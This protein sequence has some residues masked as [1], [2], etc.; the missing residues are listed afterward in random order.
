MKKQ[1]PLIIIAI[2]LII[3]FLVWPSGV[4]RPV[5]NIFYLTVKPLA[6]AGN[7]TI[8]RVSLF[9]KNFTHLGQLARENQELIKENLDL[10]SQ[11]SLLKEA[12]HENEVLKKELGFYQANNAESADKT[13]KNP[14]NLKLLPANIIG[15]SVTGYL[16][17][18]V[19]DRGK[20]DGVQTGQAIVSQGY[21]IGTVKEVLADTSEVTL[22]TDYNSLVPVILQDSRATGLLRGGLSGL[23]VEDIPL[24][25]TINPGE[26]V[27]TSGLGGDIPFGIMVGKVGEVISKKSEIFQKVTLNSPIQ[28]YYLEF[29]FVVQP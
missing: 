17:T 11:L 19:I 15:R 10:Q 9:F 23:T 24:N 6:I 20:K 12:Q 27:I 18:I 22:I 5:K 2:L 13:T 29:V 8:N 7:F 25:I 28:I 16:R 26:P 21:L 4:L 1:R 3:G 14:G